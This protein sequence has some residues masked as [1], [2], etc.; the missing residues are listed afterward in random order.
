MSRKGIS[1]SDRA[2]VDPRLLDE[3]YA[4]VADPNR[5]PQLL[6]NLSRHF[7]ARCACLFATS[8]WQNLFIMSLRHDDFFQ[9]YIDQGWLEPNVRAAPLVAE[10]A[11]RF[12]TDSDLHHPDMMAT[13]PVYRD[14]LIPEGYAIGAGTVI[15]GVADKMITVTLEGFAS[16]ASARAALPQLD[17]L[18][19]HL[20]RAA[21]L[22][23]QMNQVAAQA[24]VDALDLLNTP[25]VIERSGRLRAHN[26]Q[27]EVGM[28]DR[29]TT[30]Q[31]RIR[32]RNTAIDAKVRRALAASRTDAVVSATILLDAHAMMP[33][34]A[35]HFIPLRQ[36]AR[37]RFDADGFI[38]IAA[39]PANRSVPKAGLLKLL[40]DLTP[41]EAMLAV[42]LAA[43]RS[44][45]EA[46]IIRGIS[47]A[48]ARTHLRSIF[49]KIGCTRQSELVAML[50]HPAL[51]VGQATP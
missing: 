46:A 6:E 45:Q 43:G 4:T 51:S 26:R 2:M 16:E 19:P 28:G 41:A 1:D 49:G 33:P 23:M 25:A 38:I 9:R 22:S 5:W 21:S 7:G 35:L 36:M 30:F 27:F 24:T 3:I 39:D 29:I 10:H 37:S 31:G 20:A 34:C 44:L 50:C 32:F 14:F 12:R 15:Q 40:F 47:Y 17:R 48:T 18:R 13:L 8:E 11:P 42:E